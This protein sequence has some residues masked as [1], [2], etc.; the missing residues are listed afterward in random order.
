LAQDPNNLDIRLHLANAEARENIA[1]PDGDLA[2][3]PLLADAR[4]QYLAVL[5]RDNGNRR[6]SNG[7]RYST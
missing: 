1:H 7:W 3:D 5:A 2:K 6:L 4:Q